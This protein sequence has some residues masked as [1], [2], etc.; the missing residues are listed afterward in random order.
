MLSLRSLWY[1]HCSEH[2]RLSKVVFRNCHQKRG[3]TNKAMKNGKI[4]VIHLKNRYA[5][6]WQTNFWQLAVLIILTLLS[7][8]RAETCN[9]NGRISESS[10]HPIQTQLPSWG[11]SSTFLAWSP[12]RIC[13]RRRVTSWISVTEKWPL[14]LAFPLTSASASSNGAVTKLTEIM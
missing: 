14:P 2:E 8:L 7:V 5:L 10:Q 9:Q 1:C 6:R 13:K 11:S 3:N 12:P 4:K